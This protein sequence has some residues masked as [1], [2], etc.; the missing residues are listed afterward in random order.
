MMHFWRGELAICGERITPAMEHTE[1]KEKVTCK[2][3]LAALA[4][5]VVGTP[6]RAPKPLHRNAPEGKQRT[7][8]E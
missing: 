8:Q 6:P 5:T 2:D 3:C 7:A 4:V 1:D